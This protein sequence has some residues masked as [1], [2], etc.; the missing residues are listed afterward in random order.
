MPPTDE[1]NTAI[2]NALIECYNGEI[3]TVA[4]YIACSVNLDGVRAKHI[5]NSLEADIPEELGHA[6][7]VARRIHVIG[8]EVPGSQALSWTQTAMQPPADP[9]DVLAVIRGVI[10][11]EEAAI[12]G[13]EKVIALCDGVDYATQDMAITNLADEQEHRREFVG[14]LREYESGA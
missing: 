13:Y 9:A 2:I 5:K 6:Q 3:E 8:G 11:A 10:A 12:A 7:L 1:Q 14:F 4:N